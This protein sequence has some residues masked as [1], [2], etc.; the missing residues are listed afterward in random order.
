VIAVLLDG[1]RRGLAVIVVTGAGPGDEAMVLATLT[2][3][4]GGPSAGLEVVE[5]VVL[6]SVRP[7][8]GVVPDDELRWLELLEQAELAG[9]T[10]LDWFVLDG[11][12]ATSLAAVTG[13]PDRW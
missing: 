11:R 3:A 2:G 12:T 7:D 10:L 5:A 13:S 1:A 6:G 4:R 8:V 9:A